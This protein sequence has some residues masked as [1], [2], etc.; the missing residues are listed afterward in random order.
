MSPVDDFK[1]EG[2][3]EAFVY[4]GLYLKILIAAQGKDILRHPVMNGQVLESHVLA[5]YP[6]TDVAVVSA[7]Y[8]P[9]RS[10]A[11]KDQKVS[12]QACGFICEDT[13]SL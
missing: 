3:P 7:A 8:G 10:Y 12:I 11:G 4:P 13:D 9:C 6:E 2:N 5:A 1:I